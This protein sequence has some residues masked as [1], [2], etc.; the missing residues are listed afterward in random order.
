MAPHGSAPG[1]SDVA[2]VGLRLAVAFLF[3][4]HA[5]QKLLG[6]FGSPDYALVSLRGLASVIE[7][8][9]SPL[10]A[11]GLFTRAAALLGAI[12]MAGAY[13]V[14][15]MPRGGWPI[16]NRGE[17]STVYLIVFLYLAACGGGRYSLD[18]RLF[19]R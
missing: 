2:Y 1:L 13:I 12:E 6:W 16:E 8:I 14:V 19:G 11:V 7:L 10:I 3:I 18:R 5:P 17:L 9:V 15:H 4:F